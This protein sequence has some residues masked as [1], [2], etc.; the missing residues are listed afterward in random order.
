MMKSSRYFLAWCVIGFATNLLPFNTHAQTGELWRSWM[1]RRQRSD[2]QTPV[3]LPAGTR[4]VRDVAYGG[5]PQQRFDVYAPSNASNAPVILLVHGGGWRIGD[6][7]MPNVV[8]NKVARWIPRGI[9]VISTNYRM[10]P[11]ASP[12]QQAQDVA[13]ALATA[14]RRAP[15]WGGAADR[16]VLMGH[17][18]GA[19]LVALLAAEPAL[20]RAQGAR[21]W[22]GTVSLDSASLDVVKTMQGPH[23]PLFDQAFGSR[24]D[25][26]LAVS[27]LQQ[28]S[29][30]ITPFLAVCSSQRFESCPNAQAFVARVQSF[31]GEA[32][33]LKQ[34]LT[35]G[36][37]N[38]RLGLASAY[39]ASVEDF[40]GLLD[41]SLHQRFAQHADH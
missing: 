40:L 5:D 18:A 3:A 10:L 8:G 23:L 13:L 17:S 16:F 4:V 25:G 20:A 27:P 34:D 33:V 26:W 12:L 6:K 24:V 2:V 9:I 19:H 37:I 41:P 38:Q 35:H 1:Q 29:G 14:Q 22:L 39:T 21:P 36:E 28:L 31:G 32:R 15:E 7:A 11:G 30:R